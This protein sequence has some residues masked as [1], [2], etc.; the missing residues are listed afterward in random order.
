VLGVVVSLAIFAVLVYVGLWL[1]GRRKGGGGDA[2]S[3]AR[4]PHP[5]G[6]LGPDDDEDFLR[7]LNRQ[8]RRNRGSQDK[9]DE[10]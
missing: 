9:D 10:S 2:G 6:P 5:S 3:I 1:I 4:P 7:G 8:Q